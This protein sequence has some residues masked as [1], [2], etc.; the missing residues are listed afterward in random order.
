MADRSLTDY[1][2]SVAS[3]APAPGG[4]SVV[5]I[6]AALGAAL[7]EMVISLTR[8]G[9]ETPEDERALRTAR[10]RLTD[11]RGR[12]LAAA[13]ADEAAYRAYLAAVAL[14]KATDDERA[15]RRA[16]IQHALAAAADVPLDVASACV[17]LTDTL[18][19][20]A[21]LGNK[22]ALADVEISALLAETALRGSLINVRGNAALLHDP[23]VTDDYRHRA[24]ALE[25]AGR[26]AAARVLTAVANRLG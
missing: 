15:T 10:E 22:H 4:G 20:V 5:A 1:I 9:G 18:L 8:T 11:L 21:S 7:G 16:T 17:D 26:A 23:T 25:T 2:D 12:L 24:D 6:V 3:D 13:P 14:P 19:A